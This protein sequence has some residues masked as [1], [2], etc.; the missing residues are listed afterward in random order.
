MDLDI[1]IDRQHYIWT[2]MASNNINT[3]SHF[4]WR[5]YEKLTYFCREMGLESEID[6]STPRCFMS[7]FLLK[8]DGG[9]PQNI[10]FNVF[11]IVMRSIARHLKCKI[12]ASQW[13]ISYRADK[14]VIDAR[15]DT[16]KDRRRQRQ[17]PKAKTNKT[18]TK[19]NHFAY[20]QI[21]CAKAKCVIVTLAIAIFC[22]ANE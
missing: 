20:F 13:L 21:N 5:K 18:T 12:L 22:I 6:Y 8:S 9:T 4:L 14:L 1:H 7:T 15:T 2:W 11:V 10:H 19:H 3:Q 16:H 17:Y